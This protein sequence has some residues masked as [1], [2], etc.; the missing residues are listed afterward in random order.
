MPIRGTKSSKKG[1]FT[2]K[3]GLESRSKANFGQQNRWFDALNA[4]KT[5]CA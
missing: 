3:L 5:H 4:E 1:K 2:L